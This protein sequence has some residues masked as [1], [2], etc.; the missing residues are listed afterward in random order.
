MIVITKVM[1][2]QIIEFWTFN[3][4]NVKTVKLKMLSSV[5]SGSCMVVSTPCS[6]SS[7]AQ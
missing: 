3:D 2:K 7:R 4:R 1:E 5:K 6:L